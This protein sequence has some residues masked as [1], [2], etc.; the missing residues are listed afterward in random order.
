MN[1]ELQKATHAANEACHIAEAGH[2]ADAIKRLQE[3]LEKHPEMIG[4][5]KNYA[6]LL[7]KSGRSEEAINEL[8][9][10]I[11]AKPSFAEAWDSLGTALLQTLR[12]EAAFD[13]YTKA[14]AQDPTLQEVHSN[15]FLSTLYRCNQSERIS[16]A[17]NSW[18]QQ[19]EKTNQ[20]ALPP[21]KELQASDPEHGRLRLGFISP[22]F[23]LHSVAFFL[24]PILTEWKKFPVEI[25]L[26][27]DAQRA[28]AITAK[29]T[30]IATR[31]E[32]V[33]HAS[34]FELI[35]Q[36]R[37][38][39]VDVLF[40]LCGHFSFNRQAV[41]ARRAAPVQISWLGYPTSTFTPNIDY[42]IIDPTIEGPDLAGSERLIRIES[43][44]HCFSPLSQTPDIQAAPYLKKGQFTF[45]CFNNAVKISPQ[46][47]QTW[48]AILENSPDSRLL[49]KAS[50]YATPIVREQ[51]R[52]WI[53]PNAR[54]RERVH[55][56]ERT[57][58]YVEH[59]DCYNQVDL[60]LDTFPYNGTTTT[61]ESLWMGVPTLTLSNTHYEQSRVGTSLLKQA[62]LAAFAVDNPKAYIGLACTLAKNP[63][64]LTKYRSSLRTHLSQTTLIQPTPLV[65]ALDA[66]LR[67][68]IHEKAMP[69][70]NHQ[71]GS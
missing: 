39:E 24:L 10:C 23:R 30:A 21:L 68:L 4:A 35:E 32:E 70:N 59:L 53:S 67:K 26:Y 28:D 20:K 1:R 27:S 64:S 29:F 19:F 48:G 41:F 46:I 43:G 62:G 69:E 17:R 11:Q 16:V 18:I 40:D 7:H 12:P 66:K 44:I 38:D 9:I 14:L 13:T 33:K 34:N 42:R 37:S 58:G 5:R 52:K 22:D 8:K 49:L 60:A 61:C 57:A 25:Y 65:T 71:L 6:T 36:I 55:F 3:I 47:A 15:R 50:A 63:E 54:V 56:L 31:F 51:I 2:V 45:G